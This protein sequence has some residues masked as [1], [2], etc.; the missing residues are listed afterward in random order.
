MLLGHEICAM[1][2]LFPGQ[3]PVHLVA[4]GRLADLYG[5]AFHHLGRDIELVDV[6]AATLR[7]L[8]RILE[9]A[10]PLA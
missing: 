10:G 5:T 2:R 7:G 1:T 9:S 3:G 8:M 4:G 6:E